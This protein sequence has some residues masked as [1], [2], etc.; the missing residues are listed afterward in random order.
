MAGNRTNMSVL[1]TS[2]KHF[3]RSSSQPNKAIKR[4]KSYKDLK[5]GSKNI[6]IHRRHDSFCRKSKEI[7]KQA[8]R[9]NK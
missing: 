4:N 3:T 7:N 5:G 8:T 6:F 2:I 1:T 9:N